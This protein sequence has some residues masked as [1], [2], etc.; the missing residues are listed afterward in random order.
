MTA[1]EAR[2]LTKK[3]DPLST[4]VRKEIDEGIKREAKSGKTRAVIH[5][6][7]EHP[8]EKVLNSLVQ[9]GFKANCKYLFTQRDGPLYTYEVSW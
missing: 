5:Y 8:R 9:D 3:M 1:D 2:T 7:K 6:Y 4:K